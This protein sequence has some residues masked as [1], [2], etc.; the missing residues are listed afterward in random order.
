M[1]PLI[2]GGLV[3]I[4]PCRR[5]TWLRV[6]VSS[7]RIVVLHKLEEQLLQQALLFSIELEQELLLP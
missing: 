7:K 6:R 2:L 5:V 3:T 4:A 1:L